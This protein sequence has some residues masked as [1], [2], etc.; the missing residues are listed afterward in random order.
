MLFQSAPHFGRCLR[1]VGIKLRHFFVHGKIKLFHA[2]STNNFVQRKLCRTPGMKSSDH[3]FTWTQLD[4]HLFAEQRNP[5]TSKHLANFCLFCLTHH[6]H[7]ILSPFRL[8]QRFYST[9]RLT[10]VWRRGIGR[11]MNERTWLPFK[12]FPTGLR[13]RKATGIPGAQF[14]RRPVDAFQL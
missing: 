9:K 1:H 14:I 5:L 8:S 6:L 10:A 3:K 13:G 4:P 11:I 7:T 12:H 2:V